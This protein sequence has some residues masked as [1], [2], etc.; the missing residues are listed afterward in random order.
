LAVRRVPG[1][2]NTAAR[3]SRIRERWSVIGI[4]S[5]CLGKPA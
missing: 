2:N 5:G 4:E 1:E 3:N